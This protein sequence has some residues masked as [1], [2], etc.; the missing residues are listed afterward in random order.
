[1]IWVKCFRETGRCAA[2]PRGGS[3]SPLEKH[4]DFLLALIEVESDLTLDEVVCALRDNKIPRR[5]GSF[6]N[7]T[8]SPSKKPCGRPSSSVRT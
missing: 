4:A 5:S 6:F 7:D 8:R 1:V 3:T 2:K